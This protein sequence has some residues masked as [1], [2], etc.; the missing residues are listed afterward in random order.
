MMFRKEILLRFAVLA[1]AALVFTQCATQEVKQELE[2]SVEMKGASFALELAAQSPFKKVEMS[3]REASELMKKRN[4]YYRQAIIDKEESRIKKGLVNNLTY[5]VRKSLSN[6]VQTTLNPGEIAK[7]MKSPVAS[8]PM[9]LESITDLKNI[10]H[11]LTQS[12]WGRV[13][14]SVQADAAQRREMVNLHVLF[15]QSENL[16]KSERSLKKLISLLSALE[17][18]K[19]NKAMVVE[20]AKSQA[21]LK[22]DRGQW[23]D[24]VRDFFNAE[25]YDVEFN[26]YKSKLSFYRE[27]T[28]PEFSDWKRWRVLE[29]SGRLVAELQKQHGDSKPA[30]PG[31]S[32]ITQNLGVIGLRNNLAQPSNLNQGMAK[33]VRQMLK[34]WRDLKSVQQQIAESKPYNETTPSVADLKRVTTVYQLKKSEIEQLKTFWMMDEKCWEI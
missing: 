6:S 12:E 14:Q 32:R 11:S 1:V 27:V 25:Y 15:C 20:L 30:L 31:I 21:L 23:L 33:E 7:V 16:E 2:Q 4:P 3:W 26:G 28:D 34:N 24:Q 19:P 5:E 10:S 17:T 29:H 18:V 9:Q 13:S 8:L 22:K